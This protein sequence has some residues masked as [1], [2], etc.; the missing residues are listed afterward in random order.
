MVRY[1][2]ITTAGT[3]FINAFLNGQDIMPT[4]I[5][6]VRPKGNVFRKIFNKW[7]CIQCFL[8]KLFN[9]QG[10]MRRAVLDIQVKPEDLNSIACRLKSM[11]LDLL[12]ISKAG[13][14]SDAMMASAK[15]GA[16]NLHPSLL[17]KYRGGHPLLWMAMNYDLE[18]G[19]S[20]FQIDSKLDTGRLISQEAF[21]IQ[22][23]QSL[24][25]VEVKAVE[26]IGVKL[27]RNALA[28][29]DREGKLETKPQPA[30]SPTAFAYNLSNEEAFEMIDWENW[31]LVRV[32]H[33][34]R[35]SNFWM[36]HVRKTC[37]WN[38]WCRCSIG[39]YEFCDVEER[40]GKVSTKGGKTYFA[41]SQGKIYIDINFSLRRIIRNFIYCEFLITNMMRSRSVRRN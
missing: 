17:P 31:D 11:N 8:K 14:L 12:V 35:S 28:K 36:H 34:M 24:Y 2:L 27:V 26:K 9:P 18:G 38:H 39:N 3:Q 7:I 32:W 25:D 20:L 6:H 23:G 15:F 5:V 40:P 41:H 10:R 16:I 22:P 4:V 30:G 29:L 21:P 33:Y 13:K 19:C 1:A 37:Y